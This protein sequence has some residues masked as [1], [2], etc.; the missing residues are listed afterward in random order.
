MPSAIMNPM[1]DQVLL[2]P[3]TLKAGFW[4]IER[5]V[6]GVLSTPEIFG[7]RQIVLCGCGDSLIVARASEASL[8]AYTGL[9]VR[10]LPALEAGRYH[11]SL[12]RDK[13]LRTTLCL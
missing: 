5:A 9:P 7:I 10:A 4:E 1:R 2:T 3:Q 6:R 13:D 8:A 12:G 11:A